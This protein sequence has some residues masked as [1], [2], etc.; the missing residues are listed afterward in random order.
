[1]INFCCSFYNFISKKGDN[2]PLKWHTANIL[3][4]PTF[5]KT[6]QQG[7]TLYLRTHSLDLEIEHGSESLNTHSRIHKE[8]VS[9]NIQIFKHY[10]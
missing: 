1:M 5:Y 8:T 3:V 2:T 7:S 4:Y 10:M 6:N 9:I